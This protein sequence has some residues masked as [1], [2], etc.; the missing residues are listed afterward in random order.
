MNSPSSQRSESVEHRFDDAMLAFGQISTDSDRW[1]ECQHGVVET[2]LDEGQAAG[3]VPPAIDRL[4]VGVALQQHGEGVAQG[5][6]G[7]VVLRVLQGCG[8]GDRRRHGH[9]AFGVIICRVTSSQ[10][11]ESTHPLQRL[12]GGVVGLAEFEKGQGALGKIRAFAI[13]QL[14]EQVDR[15]AG[16][17]LLDDQVIRPGDRDERRKIRQRRVVVR[18]SR[19]TPEDDRLNLLAIE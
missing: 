14:L 18:H 4:Q 19:Q 8:L 5:A 9:S 10:L 6:S 2:V 3:G 7:L 12:A 11:D 13:E 17:P 16:S 1:L 15:I